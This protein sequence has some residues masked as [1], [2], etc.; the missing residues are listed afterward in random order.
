M[1]AST[2]EEDVEVEEDEEDSQ[3]DEEEDSD[4]L[5]QNLFVKKGWLIDNRKKGVRP[6]PR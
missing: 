5:S 4:E 3:E 2:S 1:R 6:S